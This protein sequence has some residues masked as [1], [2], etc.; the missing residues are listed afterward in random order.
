M[1]QPPSSEPSP[2]NTDIEMPL[3]VAEPV[4][5]PPRPASRS[6]ACQREFCVL[7]QIAVL[8]GLLLFIYVGLPVMAGVCSIHKTETCQ[9]IGD[10]ITYKNTHYKSSALIGLN[11]TVCYIS[12]NRLSGHHLR[13]TLDEVVFGVCGGLSILS[14]SVWAL[15]LGILFIHLVCVVLP[16]MSTNR[17]C[18]RITRFLYR[19]CRCQFRE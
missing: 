12:D 3:L 15:T 14:I 11:E 16:W 5:A 17:T 2:E 13:V 18:Q 7:L 19:V 6:T 8:Y 1:V 4:L 10:Q 9:V